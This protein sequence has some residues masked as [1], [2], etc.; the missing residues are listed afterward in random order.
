MTDHAFASRSADRDVF[1]PISNSSSPEWYGKSHGSALNAAVRDQQVGKLR[2][3][4]DVA[5]LG[6]V[7]TY[8]IPS[9]VAATRSA[10]EPLR[11]T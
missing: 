3:L 5:S 4:S 10:R 9:R 11:S 7:R 6:V 8:L 1:A 2:R